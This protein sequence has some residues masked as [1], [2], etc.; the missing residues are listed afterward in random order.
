MPDFFCRASTQ[1]VS[2]IFKGA[3]P[4][5][6]RLVWIPSQNPNSC[7][8]DFPGSRNAP[9]RLRDMYLANIDHPERDRQVW[10]PKQVEVALSQFQRKNGYSWQIEWNHRQLRVSITKALM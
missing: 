1:E 2:S 8:E 4:P 10:N 5:L 3:Y 6:G 9:E 7:A